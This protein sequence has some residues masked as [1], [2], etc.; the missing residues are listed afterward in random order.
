MD[1]QT[2]SGVGP[3]M[4]CATPAMVAASLLPGRLSRRRPAGGDDSDG[5]SAAPPPPPP[6][7]RIDGKA[8]D[9]AVA[10]ALMASAL[11]ATYLLH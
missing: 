1:H 5:G 11:V 3:A 8:V 7:W 10:Y 2:I 9:Q 6:S 4:W